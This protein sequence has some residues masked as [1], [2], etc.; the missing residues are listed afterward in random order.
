MQKL[1]AAWKKAQGSQPSTY[2]ILIGNWEEEDLQD[3]RALAQRHSGAFIDLV[4]L[5][6]DVVSQRQP[7]S[8]PV[9]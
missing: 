7:I 5:Q 2:K 6:K 1:A 9:Q 3:K 4:G 8:S